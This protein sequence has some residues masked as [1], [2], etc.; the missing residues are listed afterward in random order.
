MKYFLFAVNLCSTIFRFKSFLRV[1]FQMP[2]MQKHVFFNV[3]AS[4][5]EEQY[6]LHRFSFSELITYLHICEHF[7]FK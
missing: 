1:P 5:L 7:P 3:V 6:I 2:E 4:C